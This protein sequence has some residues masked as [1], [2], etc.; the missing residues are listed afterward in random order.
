MYQKL[1]VENRTELALMAHQRDT[2]DAP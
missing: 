2:P 1:G